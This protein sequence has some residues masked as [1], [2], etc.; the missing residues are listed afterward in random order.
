[1]EA[2]YTTS[3]PRR[4]PKASGK[5]I[6]ASAFANPRDETNS[7]GSQSRLQ[8]QRTLLH[9]HRAARPHAKLKLHICTIVQM[10]K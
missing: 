5:R 4:N 2:G 7:D 10:R 6:R 9:L 1:M 8:A 3:P